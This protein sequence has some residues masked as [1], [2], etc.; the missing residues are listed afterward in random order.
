ML[1]P[2]FMVINSEGSNGIGGTVGTV[3]GSD[4]KRNTRRSKN[5][6]LG[7]DLYL[8]ESVQTSEML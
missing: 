3:S 6:T 7:N 1:F 2:E 5:S 4:G 8:H